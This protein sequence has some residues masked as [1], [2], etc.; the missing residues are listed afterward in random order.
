MERIIHKVDC[1]I[2]KFCGKKMPEGEVRAEDKEGNFVHWVELCSAC[3]REIE[4]KK[5]GQ[6]PA[7]ESS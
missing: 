6:K 4:E 1:I 2:C 3:F 5:D 7:N